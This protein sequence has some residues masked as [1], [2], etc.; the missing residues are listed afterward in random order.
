MKVSLTTGICGGKSESSTRCPKPTYTGPTAHPQACS[1]GVHSG[2]RDLDQIATYLL[3]QELYPSQMEAHPP[4]RTPDFTVL[5]QR[6][7]DTLESTWYH[8]L[9]FFK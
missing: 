1:C 6:L 5:C 7:H 2:D 9:I 4:T 3:D 8:Q